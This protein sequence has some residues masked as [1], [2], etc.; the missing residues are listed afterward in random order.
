MEKEKV[1]G[2]YMFNNYEDEEYNNYDEEVEI[3]NNNKVITFKN[4]VTLIIS[5]LLC[6]V[7]FVGGF[8]P[9]GWLFLVPAWPIKFLL[10]FLL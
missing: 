5:F 2:V 9:L 10:L 6:Q 7:Q 3:K 4:I 8:A 1:W